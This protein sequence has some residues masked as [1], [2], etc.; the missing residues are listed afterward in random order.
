[1]KIRPNIK[2]CDSC[3]GLLL[4]FTIKSDLFPF[5]AAKGGFACEAPWKCFKLVISELDCFPD[6]YSQNNKD[7]RALQLA[8]CL[9]L[10]SHVLHTELLRLM[11]NDHL[12]FTRQF[13]NRKERILE[14]INKSPCLPNYVL[15]Y[16]GA[17]PT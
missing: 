17:T 2:A 6:I 3:E 11:Q 4:L 16:I 12:L 7:T 1:M 15:K 14:A 13:E 10:L 8:S 5:C 9:A